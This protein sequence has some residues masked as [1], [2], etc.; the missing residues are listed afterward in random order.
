MGF[1]I[2]AAGSK[3]GATL[4]P[5]VASLRPRWAASLVFATLPMIA[6]LVCLLLPETKGQRLRDTVEEEED[7]S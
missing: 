2:S 6:A 7:S 4:A 3:L 1:S 5:F